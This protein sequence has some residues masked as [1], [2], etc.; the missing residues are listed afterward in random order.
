MYFPDF[1]VPSTVRTQLTAAV[2]DNDGGATARPLIAFQ[3][4]AAI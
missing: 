1:T 3:G 4:T 2:T